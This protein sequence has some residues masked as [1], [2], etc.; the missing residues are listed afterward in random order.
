M[1]NL[2]SFS[3]R[4]FFLHGLSGAGKGELFKRLSLL[5]EESGVQVIYFS[6]GDGFRALGKKAEMSKKGKAVLAED[7]SEALELMAK[8]KQVK[9]LGAIAIPTIQIFNELIKS[10]I[11][12]EKKILIFDGILRNGESMDEDTKERIPSQLLQVSE[13]LARAIKGHFYDGNGQE[14]EETKM[15]IQTGQI[16]ANFIQEI[17]SKQDINFKDLADSGVLAIVAQSLRYDSCHALVDVTVEDAEILMRLR[18]ALALK[19]LILTLAVREEA[20]PIINDLLE[21]YKLQT[22][23]FEVKEGKLH[24]K[25]FDE[26]DDKTMDTFGTDKNKAVLIDGKL[27]EISRN[28]LK[29]MGVNLEKT[30]G[31]PKKL[32]EVLKGIQVQFG[33]KDEQL[34]RYDDMPHLSR[35][36]RIEEFITKALSGIIKGELGLTIKYPTSKEVI[37]EYS[38]SRVN[39]HKTRIIANGPNRG[40]DLPDFKKEA[41]SLAQELFIQAIGPEGGSRILIESD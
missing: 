14:T 8:G 32:K 23:R 34:P 1:I 12:G 4:I 2:A 38:N 25:R 37:L 30:D 3:S 41:G 6:S 39:I 24:L 9:H 18:S 15:L 20:T 16:D 36:T 40:I 31:S 19:D 21:L 26:S 13:M 11:G 27:Q 17:G 28:L 5:A 35:I 22:G 33:L 7:E 29:N 10:T